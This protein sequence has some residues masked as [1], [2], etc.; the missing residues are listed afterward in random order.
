MD[1]SEN[2]TLHSIFKV[3]DENFDSLA[4]DLFNFQYEQNETY[5]KYCDAIHCKALS[6]KAIEDIPYLPISFF[7]SKDVKT[8]SF[9]TSTI[10]ES[11]GTT[12]I[13]TSRHFVKDLS[14]YK[15]SFL[16]TFELFYGEVTKYCIIG[17]LPSYLERSHS[18]L[19]MM[20]NDLI[21]RSGNVE[22][23]FY[24]YDHAKLHQ[25]LLINEAK[26]QPTILIGVTYALLDFA[27]KYPM[28]LKHTIVMETG[29]MKG[30]NKELTREE[31]HTTLR[32]QLGVSKVH[33]E[34]GMTELLSQAYSKDNGHFYS[35]PWMKVLA[36]S[37]DD[38]FEVRTA[39]A[40]PKGIMGAANIIDFA[41][42]YSCCFIATDDVI[43]LYPDGNFEVLGR[44]DNSDLRGCGL[45]II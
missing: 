31:V 19:V 45:M 29:G 30:R 40:I 17:L 10:F 41:N 18:S 7:K 20:T 38:P 25:T 14:I 5:R 42:V 3:S 9:D 27:D 15:K 32:L 16:E 24:L 1:F 26:Q 39:Y 4:I 21:I 28:R 44:L 8:T 6:V 13:N 36:R 12:G 11:S 34:Y 22:S 37:E 43:R 35:P 2:T 33:A 23:G